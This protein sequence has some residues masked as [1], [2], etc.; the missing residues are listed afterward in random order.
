MVKSYPEK[1]FSLS[2]GYPFDSRGCLKLKK[3]GHGVRENLVSVKIST[4]LIFMLVQIGCYSWMCFLN[5]CQ[6][7]MSVTYHY[8]SLKS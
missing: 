2:F 5:F 8:K 3:K 4:F 6:K 7:T 1:S